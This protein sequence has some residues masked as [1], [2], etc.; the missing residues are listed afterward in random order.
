MGRKIKPI[1]LTEEQDIRLRDMELNTNLPEQ[2][3][4]RAQIVRATARGWARDQI[5]EYVGYHPDTIKRVCQR[6]REQGVEGLHEKPRP[7]RVPTWPPA[8]EA[9]VRACLEQDQVWDC[10]RLS[11]V[12]Q[13]QCQVQL[14][15]EA[16]RLRL[17]AMGYTWQRT[18]YGPAQAPDSEAIQTAQAFLDGFKKG[19]TRGWYICGTW[20]KPAA[21]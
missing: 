19:Q 4:I 21:A 13:E 8:V 16:I 20:T 11:E 7:G 9:V 18:R 10:T 17:R 1:R 12:L 2:T 5:A 15:R 3:R 6:F 14:G